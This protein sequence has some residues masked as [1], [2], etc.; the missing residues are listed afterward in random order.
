MVGMTDEVIVFYSG[1]K[2][3]AIVLDLA[4]RHFKH[5]F[6]VFMYHVQDLSFQESILSWAEKRYGT[7]IYRVPHFELSTY[8]RRGIYCKADLRV[9]EVGI[10]D[11][12]AHVRSAFGDRRWIMAGERCADSTVRNAMIKASGSVDEK[13][14]RF[15]PLAYWK[16]ADVLAYIKQHNLKV[17][18]ESATL[19]HSLALT[20]ADLSAMKV[21]YPADFAKVLKVLPL[22]EVAV[23]RAQAR[24]Y[25]KARE[26]DAKLLG[27]AR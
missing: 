15:Y 9:R 20:D 6:P 18:P 2:D 4:F 24:A 17:S 25:E 10:A 22:A 8:L 26:K 12:Y 5:V 13:R 11:I 1:G 23:L 19:G 3:S 27:K 16:K 14:G 21:L 7:S